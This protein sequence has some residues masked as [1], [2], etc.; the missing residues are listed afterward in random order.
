MSIFAAVDQF[1][2]VAATPSSCSMKLFGKHDAVVAA[3]DGQ[4]PRAVWIPRGTV[5]TGEG[6]GK[7]S[8]LYVFE[9]K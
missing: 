3:I 1:L 7:A 9:V 5:H 6:A 2:L 4:Q 8:R